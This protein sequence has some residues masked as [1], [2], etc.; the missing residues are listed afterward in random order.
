[1]KIQNLTAVPAPI[2]RAARAAFE[3][4][5]DRGGALF[6]VTELICPAQM[7]ELERVHR[8][9]IQVDVA[10]LMYA[11]LGVLMAR[12]I[13]SYS[14]D[15]RTQILEAGADLPPEH[16][17]LLQELL[18]Q[19]GLERAASTGM[20]VIAERR[21]F[22]HVT[23][24]AVNVLVSGQM[25]HV[26]AV[27]QPDGWAI[28]DWK[29]GSVWEAMDVKPE[30]EQQLNLYAELLRLN[31]FSPV[32]KLENGFLFRDWS[33]RRARR[34]RDYPRHQF[35]R[36]PARVW[37]AERAGMFLVE[38]T[39]VHMAAQGNPPE[40]TLAE[41]WQKP[42]AW[43]VRKSPTAK[44]ASAVLRSERDALEWL[45]EAKA[46]RPKP[47]RLGQVEYRPTE[48]IRCLDYCR[49]QPFCEQFRRESAKQV[50]VDEAPQ[51]ESAWAGEET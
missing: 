32:V 36:I 50:L 41:K 39:A 22:A 14:G 31:G 2:E 13:A 10:D 51:R 8:D 23:V 27:E 37:P 30:R 17:R 7:V 9:E 6:T 49:A 28:T 18:D 48:A 38:R 33:K 21:L 26:L 46:N 44:R 42:A 20:K 16:R 1:M 5:R 12:L 4:E 3:R 34:E 25:D 15:T 43:A 24:G 47:W 19:L 40:C 29:V 45:G 11:L 35:Q